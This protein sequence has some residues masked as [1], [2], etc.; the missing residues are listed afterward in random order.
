MVKLHKGGEIVDRRLI[1]EYLNEILHLEA[2]IEPYET[3]LLGIPP[4]LLGEFEFFTL[5]VLNT[6]LLL[7]CRMSE[8]A[9][10]PAILSKRMAA[11]ASG[12]DGPVCVGLINVTPHNRMRL[13]EKGIQFIVPRTQMY[14]PC[15]GVDLHERFSL[16]KERKA[17][18]GPSAQML[19]L[20]AQSQKLREM[21]GKDASEKLK[22]AP[23]TV[24]RAFREL[25]S[26]GLC[27][28]TGIRR[29]TKYH[30]EADFA[31]LWDK[32][33]AHL[34]DPVKKRVWID[35]F[36]PTSDAYTSGM[37]ALAHYTFIA[38]DSTR[39]VAVSQEIAKI[40]LAMPEV[41]QLPYQEPGAVQIEI[42]KYDPAILAKGKIVDQRSLYLCFRDDKDDRIQIELE[43]MKN[44]W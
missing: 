25:E 11:A 16:P 5:K 27:V 21:K 22:I 31:A 3:K 14:L 10:S 33:E 2:K 41:R 20:Y 34:A 35:R 40:V 9:I 13:I 29:K 4:F 42:W 19:F 38:G 28:R 24:S 26:H 23:I 30:F 7:L 43:R 1:N 36:P 32:A 8:E 44:K 18:L 6:T 37:E 17:S 15:L 12:W 39:I